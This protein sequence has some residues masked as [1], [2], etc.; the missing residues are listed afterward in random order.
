MPAGRREIRMRVTPC[1]ESPEQITERLARATAILIRIAERVDAGD[2]ENAEMP[3][4]PD[5]TKEHSPRV[6]E[7]PINSAVDLSPGDA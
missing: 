2:Q 4:I 6:Q 3:S 1:K 7:D 5:E